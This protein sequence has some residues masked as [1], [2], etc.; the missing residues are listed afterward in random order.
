[1]RREFEHAV[2]Y[3]IAALKEHISPIPSVIFD[4]VMSLGLYPKVKPD[5]HNAT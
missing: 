2:K 1:M 4:D 5:E 3:K